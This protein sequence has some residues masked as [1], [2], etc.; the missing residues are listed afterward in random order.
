MTTGIAAIRT[1][2]KCICI[3]NDKDIF[4]VGRNRVKEYLKERNSI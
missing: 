4:D 1:K 2:R 3:E